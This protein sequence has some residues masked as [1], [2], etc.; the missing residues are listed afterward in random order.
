MTPEQA[1]EFQRKAGR[2]RWRGLTADERSEINRKTIE[3]RWG[4]VAYAKNQEKADR[5]YAFLREY[6]SAKRYAP[7][8]REIRHA[9]REDANTVKR[10]LQIPERIGRI[11]RHRWNRGITLS[12]LGAQPQAVALSF[13]EESA[14]QGSAVIVVPRPTTKCYDCDNPAVAGKTRCELHLARVREACKRSY[15]KRRTAQ[16]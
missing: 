12:P 1:C 16:T 7:T 6:I 8:W 3:R 13:G 5:L 14:A 11:Q 9:M 10:L 2:G 15:A 4:Q